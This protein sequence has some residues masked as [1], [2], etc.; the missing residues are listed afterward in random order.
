MTNR[1][2]RVR[3]TTGMS[4]LTTVIQ[5]STRSPSLSNQATKRNKRQIGKEE[6]KLSLFTDDMIVFIEN[7]KDSTSRL[8]ELIKQF[9]SVA[10][11][12]INAQKS[13][14]FLYTNNETEERQIKESSHLQMHPKA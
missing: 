6:V 5:H 12:K 9:S 7:P 1:N 8:L 13:V 14:A 10:R 2:I 4:N 3:N 11:Y